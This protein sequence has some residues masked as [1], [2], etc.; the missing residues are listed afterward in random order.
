M[1]AHTIGERNLNVKFSFIMEREKLI[2]S[3]KMEILKIQVIK[4]FEVKTNFLSIMFQEISKFYVREKFIVMPTI[5]CLSPKPI[6]IQETI[7]N[8]VRFI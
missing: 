7:L 8:L 2:A 4:P 3:V 1:K 6:T 5:A